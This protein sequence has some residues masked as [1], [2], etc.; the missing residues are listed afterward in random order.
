M[1][2]ELA[3]AEKVLEIGSGTGQ[4]AVYFG[5][6]LQHLEW[7]TSDLEEQHSAI[8]AWL[9]AAQLANV[10]APLTLDVRNAT[11]PAACYDA[12]FS[13]NTAH[14]M[15]Y[16][17]V[18]KLFALV[19][20]VLR[21][22]GVFFLYGPFRQHGRFNTDSNEQFHRSLKATDSAMGIRH[23]EDLDRLGTAGGLLRRRLYAMPANNHLGVWSKQA[24]E[25]ER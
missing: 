24:G 14:I 23:I 3:T 25:S 5:A 8:Q 12:V 22:D 10:R 7:Q 4:H 17:S 18:A 20:R 11:L 6:A 19:A 13:A 16:S 1:R 21:D 2:R 9:A 15:S